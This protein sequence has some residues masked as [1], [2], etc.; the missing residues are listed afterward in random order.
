MER[1]HLD[2]TLTSLIGLINSDL[3]FGPRL[4]CDFFQEVLVTFA[5]PH[6]DN[7]FSL[8]GILACFFLHGDDHS[9]RYYS[10]RTWGQHWV[11]I[12][13]PILPSTSGMNLG[14]VLC[15]SVFT[16]PSVEKD[17]NSSCENLII[18]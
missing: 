5:S 2:P 16:S 12:V 8:S 11:V 4:S 10:V 14:K 18:Q 9:L 6:H 3:P 7:H 17:E 13:I 15:L 1:S